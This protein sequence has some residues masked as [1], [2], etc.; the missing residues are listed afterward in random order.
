MNYQIM[1]I[2]IGEAK[3]IVNIPEIDTQCRTWML[4]TKQGIFYKEFI[5][6]EFIAIGWNSLSKADLE[7]TKEDVL[8]DTIERNYGDRRPGMALGKCIRFVFELKEHDI[9]MIVGDGKVT[10]AEIGEYFEENAHTYSIE[11]ELEV[12]RLIDAGFEKGMEI[13]CPYLKRRKIEVIKEVDIDRLNPRLYAGVISNHHSL[14]SLDDY[15]RFVYSACYD[16][17]SYREVLSVVFHVNKKKDIHSL[18]LSSFMY[19]STQLLCL[20]DEN[21]D[22]STKVNLNSVGDML[23]SNIGASNGNY[24]LCIILFAIILFGSDIE[25]G[26]VKIPVPSIRS[27]IKSIVNRKYDKRM[28][29]LALEEKEA[30]VKGLQLDNMLKELNIMD[31][32]SSDDEDKM[33]DTIIARIS[34]SAEKLEIGAVDS[35]LIY[36]ESKNTNP[37]NKSK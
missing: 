23:L 27:F 5:E 6:S 14:S 28:K 19:H 20:E 2:D 16:I 25:W 30:Q 34:E 10:L 31:S 33:I 1:T 7:N 11:K 15:A 8:K 24:F 29:E 12:N 17:Y 35:N 3:A 32:E 13:P 22:I 37:E 36:F 18:D 9:V 4:R 26:G 21:D